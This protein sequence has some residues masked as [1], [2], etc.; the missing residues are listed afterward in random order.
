MSV[1]DLLTGGT[2]ESKSW[3]NPIFNNLVCNDITCNTINNG[4]VSETAILLKAATNQITFQE[5][6]TGAANVINS[7]RPDASITFNFPDI[8]DTSTNTEFVVTTGD[9]EI[10]GT[11]TFSSAILLTADGTPGNPQIEIQPGA[12]GNSFFITS[13][14]PG[15]PMTEIEIPDPGIQTGTQFV[16]SQGNQGINGIKSFSQAI[17]TPS[18]NVQNTSNQIVLGT[19]NTITI[20]ANAPSVSRNYTIP[21]VGGNSSFI[22]NNSPS[23]TLS[24]TSNQIILGPNNLIT[25]TPL[26]ISASNIVTPGLIYSFPSL[27]ANASFQMGMYDFFSINNQNYTMQISDSGKMVRIAATAPFTITLPVGDTI[28]PS[29]SGIHYLFV[30]DGIITATGS[31]TIVGL[32]SAS[33]ANIKGTICYGDAFGTDISGNPSIVINSNSRRGDILHFILV[34][35]VWSVSGFVGKVAAITVTPP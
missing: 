13:I 3:C 9:Q 2:P 19:T 32:T 27:Q 26:T 15:N 31:Y 12:G 5:N 29:A 28:L 30:V 10:E 11:K 16:L 21:D 18:I 7:A 4:G 25:T 22:L 8:S 24:D 20:N 35:S 17:N 14:N 1:Y 34:D 23:I 6:A 33:I